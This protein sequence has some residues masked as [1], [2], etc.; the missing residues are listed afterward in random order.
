M[1]AKQYKFGPHM[2]DQQDVFYTTDLSYAF[3]NL[4]PVLPGKC[5]FICFFDTDCGL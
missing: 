3:V 2:I 4:R 5:L 1:E